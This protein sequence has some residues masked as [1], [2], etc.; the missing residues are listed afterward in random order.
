M[1]DKFTLF[2]MGRHGLAV[3][4]ILLKKIPDIVQL[5]VSERNNEVLNDYYDEIKSLCETYN[6]EF[7]NRKCFCETNSSYAIAVSWRWMIQLPASKL[8]VLH[9]SL[10][11]RLRGFNP[12][13]TALINGDEEIG[14]TALYAD[15]EY[16]K[17]SIIAQEKINI[18]YPMDIS[19]AIKKLSPLYEKIVLFLA[20]KILNKEPI[21]GIAQNE[22]YATYSLWRD[23]E[24]YRID[25]SLSAFAIQRFICAVGSPYKGAFTIADR[26]RYRILKSSLVDDIII[27]NRTAGKIIFID[28]GS[29][30]IVCGKGLLLINEIVEDCSGF[31]ALPW[32]KMRSRFS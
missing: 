2:I 4:H 23:E 30:V 25:W 12:L 17:G 5:V 8:I 7:I 9:D 27:E 21:T 15:V 28:N 16:D 32:K 19:E 11:P 20:A 10:L 14:V 3:L 13:V 6:I 24:D 29:P 1:T 26:K 31:S 18:S 22:K